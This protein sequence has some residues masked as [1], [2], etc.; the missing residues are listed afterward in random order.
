MS[1]GA[2]PSP[3]VR[4]NARR[5]SL[6]VARQLAAI[7]AAMIVWA[8]TLPMIHAES[9]GQAGLVAGAPIAFY[10]ALLV[11]LFGATF[12]MSLTQPSAWILAAYITALALV[13]YGTI[14]AI[15]AAPQYAW[16][17]KHIGVVRLI[18]FQGALSPSVDIYNRWPGLFSLAAAF[19][20]VTGSDPVSYAGWFEFLFA[21]LDAMVVAAIAF[22]V[23]R[24]RGVAA[25]S[26][27]IWLLTNW[28]GQTYF[29]PQGLAFFL[30]LVIMLIVLRRFGGGG[31]AHRRLTRILGSIVRKAQPTQTLA[32]PLGW[33]MWQSVAV[34][35][36]LDAV[37]VAVHQLTPY[38]VLLQ[39]GALTA[40]GFRPRWLIFAFAGLTV[41]YLYPNLDYVQSH[42]GL[43]SGTNPLDN[44]KVAS[45]D[46]H[47]AWFYQNVGA[48]L[49]LTTLVFA[50]LGALRLA[51]SGH[52]HRVIPIAALALVPYVVLFGNS[53]GGEGVLRSFLFSSPWLA[54]L[55][56]WGLSMLRSKRQLP[57]AFGVVAMLCGL[58]VF[59]FVGN[60]GTNVIPRD[61]VD[62]GS[63]FYDHAPAGSA[64]MLAGD[65]FPLRF[66]RRYGAMRSLNL[67]DDPTLAGRA[68]RR[69]DV[70]HLAAA[71]L[72]ESAHGYIVFSTTQRRF[73]Q[74][75]GTTP[76]RALEQLER[77]V[78]ASPMF[79]LWSGNEHARIYRLR[80]TKRC[81][82]SRDCPATVGV[83]N[84]R[85][86]RIQ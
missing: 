33:S 6:S 35:I 57:V 8:L 58:F 43:F 19:S 46:Y 79:A 62:A 26:A 31:G 65:D 49:S 17:Y 27:L 70:R 55:I 13:L 12:V 14:P 38:M 11:L 60:A 42:F 45:V 21:W 73:A 67:F 48:L 28:V 59:A 24:D 53:Y 54:I 69:R 5:R 29:S 63:Y 61:E 30:S 76:P 68:F 83:H 10:A 41:A 15:S 78:A 37:I 25:M 52:A 74:Y 40:L 75:Y 51:R 64:L 20:R 7:A 39:L 47:R 50:M 9:L 18:D 85:P 80:M 34:V 82:L 66:D 4:T 32:T 86:G 81:Q 72:E 44:A 2:L 23:T 1:A 77:W 3:T 84:P 22:A 36:A 56:A 16:T 71:L